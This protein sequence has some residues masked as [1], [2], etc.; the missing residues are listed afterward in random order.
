[1]DKLIRKFLLLTVLVIALMMTALSNDTKAYRGACCDRCYSCYESC[2]NGQPRSDCAPSSSDCYGDY[3][4]CLRVC[5][6]ACPV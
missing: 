2:I 6:E 4:N 1:M 3:L 5:P